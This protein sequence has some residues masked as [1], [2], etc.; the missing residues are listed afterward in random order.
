MTEKNI[1]EQMASGDWFEAADLS[2]AEERDHA[3][4]VLRRFNCD[5]D[6]SETERTA[7]LRE[8]FGELGEHSSFSPGLQVDYGYNIFVGKRCFFNFGCTMLDGASIRFGDDVW[9]GPQVVF[10]TPIHPL[11]GEERRIRFDE[12]GN[13]HLW[14]R[15]E[16]ITVGSDVWIASNV[17]INAGVT[18]GDGAV[19][20]SGSVVTKDIP[21]RVLAH[22]APCKPVREITEADRMQFPR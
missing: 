15:N 4:K 1:R 17:T 6:L 16:A 5:P 21:P 2:L 9:V 10:A 11:L 19:I 8:L 7:L 20:G 13:S 22:G 14:E 12:Q 18:I 3:R